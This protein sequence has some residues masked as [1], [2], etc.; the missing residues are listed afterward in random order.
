MCISIHHTKGVYG[1]TGNCT[2]NYGWT[3]ATLTSF[4]QWVSGKGIG[5]LAIWRADIY[6]MYCSPAGV[7][8]WFY[9]ILTAFL[10]GPVSDRSVLNEGNPNKREEIRR[11]PANQASDNDELNPGPQPPATAKASLT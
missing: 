10:K 6:P 2:G 7:A 5:R 3:E 1:N 11:R 4:V 8:E 9:P